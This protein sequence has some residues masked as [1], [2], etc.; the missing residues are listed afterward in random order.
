MGFDLK[1]L[2]PLAGFQR[3]F[4][5]QGLVSWPRR[6]SSWPWWAGWPTASCAAGCK[7][8]WRSARPTSPARRRTSSTWP[9][10]WRCA[11]ARLPGAG[12]RRLRLPALALHALDAHVQR[13]DQRRIQ[14]LGRRSLLRSRIRGQQRRIARMRMMASVPKAN[15]VITNPTH[16]AWRCNTTPRPWGRRGWWPRALTTSPS[17]SPISPAATASRSSRTSPWRGVVQSGGDRSRD[18][19]RNVRGGGRSTGLR[20]PPERAKVRQGA[21]LDLSNERKLWRRQL[22]P[23]PSIP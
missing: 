19:P 2:N 13:R 23:N 17:A 20:V 9:S 11:W 6:C 4:S 10:T 1:R 3:I 22:L 15:V 12:H 18:P 14:A 7:T 5:G 16:L 21:S 8:C